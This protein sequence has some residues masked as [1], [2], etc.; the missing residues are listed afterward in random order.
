MFRKWES[1]IIKTEKKITGD[2]FKIPLDIDLL[3]ERQKRAN[4]L[5]EKYP[6]LIIKFLDD[7]LYVCN[8][9]HL[10]I[11]TKISK[12]FPKTTIEF[13]ETDA[14]EPNHTECEQ[15]LKN[16]YTNLIKSLDKLLNLSYDPQSEM[17]STIF[18][19]RLFFFHFYF[20][21]FIPSF[22]F[23][24]PGI[25]SRL[26]FN[27][28]KILLNAIL[29]DIS[30]YEKYEE[31]NRLSTSREEMEKK[32]GWRIRVVKEEW[33]RMKNRP[34]SRNRTSEIIFDRLCEKYPGERKDIPKPRTIWEYLKKHEKDWTVF[35]PGIET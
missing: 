19:D 29:V 28:G 14:I 4:F 18:V 21:K 34:P 2:L 35:S 11:L 9:K 5:V 1:H 20:N 16:H 15:I 12:S 33:L 13:H 24:L 7:S 23:S 8:Q 25:D 3:R 32:K 17:F 22:G 31:L 6:S 30:C 10:K 27:F 26:S